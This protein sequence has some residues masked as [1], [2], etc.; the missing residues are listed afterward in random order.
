MIYGIMVNDLKHPPPLHHHHHP[1]LSCPICF[2]NYA[3]RSAHFIIFSFSVLISTKLNILEM[4]P[5]TYK[6]K[7]QVR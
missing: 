6:S 4:A 3:I 5:R 7:V 1:L 2:N